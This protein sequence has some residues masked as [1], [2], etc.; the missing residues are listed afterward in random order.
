MNAR[1]RRT[2]DL[3]LGLLTLGANTA[4]LEMIATAA[5][6]G[7]GAAGLRLSGRQPGDAWPSVDGDPLAFRR[8]RDAADE[9]QVR[10]S[11]IGGYYISPRVRA[12][13]LLANVA[14]AKAVGAPMI[15]QGCSEGNHARVVSLLRDYAKAA[16]DEGIRIA[17]EFMPMSELKSLTQTCEL[18]AECG[19]ANVGI[20][21][22]ALHLAR[23]NATAADV[24]AL[25]ASSI[26]LTQL[27][28]ASA[29]LPQGSTLYDEAMAGRMYVGDGGLDL[30][31][32]V[33]AVPPDAEIELETPVLAHA[34]LPSVQRARN[35]AE[36]AQR[37]FDRHFT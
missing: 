5:S 21:I 6:A 4:P 14:A 31:A 30:A 17:L 12:S 11:S 20:L 3:T 33:A 29:H 8:I 36:A 22:D 25:D 9:K 18:I 24:A 7:F 26:Y 10:I 35:A 2:S 13:H 15:L 37:F 1:H 28:D 34:G 19:A 32:L 16:S 27:S 23:S